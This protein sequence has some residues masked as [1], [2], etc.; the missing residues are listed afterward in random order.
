MLM[1]FKGDVSTD[2]NRTNSL[3]F[4]LSLVPFET[5]W[6]IGI[7]SVTYVSISRERLGGREGQFR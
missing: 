4:F 7:L 6:V 1:P 5:G 2:S 3:L